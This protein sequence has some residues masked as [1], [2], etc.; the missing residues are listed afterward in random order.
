M[1][2]I[3]TF[4]I[5]LSKSLN[6]FKYAFNGLREV[7]KNE[8]NF[9][10][11]LLAAALTLSLAFHFSITATEWLFVILFIGLVTMA[12]VFNTALEKLVDWQSPGQHPWAGKIKDMAAGAVLLTSIAALV[13]GIII[14]YKYFIALIS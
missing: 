6:S 12:E 10:F 11:H 1:K 9:R 2:L 3:A 7:T 8:N 5:S 4:R 14:F 13:G